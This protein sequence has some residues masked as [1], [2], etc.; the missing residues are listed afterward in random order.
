VCVCFFC[1]SEKISDVMANLQST[2]D[3][4][5]GTAA[6]RQANLEESYELFILLEGVE[7]FKQWVAERQSVLIVD[8]L[9][10]D[11]EGA[12]V[13]DIMSVRHFT[14]PYLLKKSLDTFVSGKDTT[15][16]QGTQ[17]I[18]KLSVMG[19]ELLEKW[20]SCDKTLVTEALESVNEM[21]ENFNKDLMKFEKVIRS[22]QLWS[23]F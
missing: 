20:P 13:S 18:D 11:T 4:L 15:S 1:C 17:Q 6:K 2:Y 8:E 7:E 12:L 19:K 14:L 23:Q 10:N 22:I 21:W 5:M 16:K 3:T 9:G